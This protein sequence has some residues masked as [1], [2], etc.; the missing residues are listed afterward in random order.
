MPQILANAVYN[1][2][3]CVTVLQKF[4]M[5][6]ILH[7]ILKSFENDSIKQS[8]GSRFPISGQSLGLTNCSFYISILHFLL[9]PVVA[10]IQLMSA[11]QLAGITFSSKSSAASLESKRACIMLKTTGQM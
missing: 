2:K 7:H 1:I 10:T 4:I 8:K 11:R 3:K 6:K 5:F 9:M